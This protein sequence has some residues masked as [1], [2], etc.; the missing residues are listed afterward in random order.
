MKCHS[1]AMIQLID[2]YTNTDIKT[3]QN[4]L[5]QTDFPKMG[6]QIRIGIVLIS[7]Y[8]QEIKIS[9]IGAPVIF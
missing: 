2:L 4:D 8:Q 7:V 3:V 6:R 9:K 5:F 1:Y